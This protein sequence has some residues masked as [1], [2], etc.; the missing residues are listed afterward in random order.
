MSLLSLQFID[1]L[2]NYLFNNLNWRKRIR[3]GNWL[4]CN[5]CQSWLD[6]QEHG[7]KLSV[8]YSLELILKFL[9]HPTLLQLYYWI[10]F[11]K[12]RFNI[13]LRLFL[14]IIIVRVLIIRLSIIIDT[15]FESEHRTTVDCR[16][17]ILSVTNHATHQAALIAPVNLH[18]LALISPPL[19][20]LLMSAI[21]V[22]QHPRT[23][24][25]QRRGWYFG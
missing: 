9:T 6:V 3:I 14:V 11:F 16:C 20:V 8:I 19:P 24:R 23:H 21:V 12:V 10:L 1:S 17:I 15:W 4:D 7:V 2:N 22:H 25:G 5:L 13:L 18:G